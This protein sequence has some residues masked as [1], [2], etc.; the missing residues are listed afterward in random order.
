MESAPADIPAPDKEI[1]KA[2]TDALLAHPDGMSHTAWETVAKL[3]ANG[4]AE[5]LKF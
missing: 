1:P 2:V 5:Q 4:D 3:A